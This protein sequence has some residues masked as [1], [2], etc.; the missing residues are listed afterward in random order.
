MDGTFDSAPLLFQ[1]LYVICAPLDSVVS[2][3]YAFLPNKTQCTYEERLTAVV[4]KCNTLGIQPDPITVVTD[5]KRAIIKA[6]SWTLGIDI[7]CH[8]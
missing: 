6:V 7:R 3:V 4:D 8:G 1:Q 5:F 2:C